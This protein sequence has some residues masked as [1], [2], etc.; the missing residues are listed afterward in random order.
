MRKNFHLRWVRGDWT[1]LPR[2]LPRI[3]LAFKMWRGWPDP[4]GNVRGIID[5]GWMNMPGLSEEQAA[6]LDLYSGWTDI[7]W[8]LAWFMAGSITAAPEESANA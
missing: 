5:N 3:H 8:P 6:T 4:W 1:R 2:P 7:D